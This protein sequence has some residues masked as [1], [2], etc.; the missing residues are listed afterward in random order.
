M[1]G[2][3]ISTLLPRDRSALPP[4]R[5]G[6]AEA[7]SEGDVCHVAPGGFAPPATP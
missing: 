2:S 6:V 1:V 3:E 5:T 4:R 7:A